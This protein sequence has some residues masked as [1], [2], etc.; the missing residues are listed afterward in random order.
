M[1][2]IVSIDNIHDLG[3]EFLQV[4]SWVA[5]QVHLKDGLRSD[6]RSTNTIQVKVTRD[7]LKHCTTARSGPFTSATLD[8]TLHLELQIWNALQPFDKFKSQPTI[9]T[10]NKLGWTS[11]KLSCVDFEGMR[12]LGHQIIWPTNIQTTQKQNQTVFQLLKPAA[13]DGMGSILALRK[14]LESTISLS[15]VVGNHLESILLHH[16]F[17][18]HHHHQHHPQRAHWDNPWLELANHWGTRSISAM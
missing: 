13:V 16:H 6:Q 7:H 1:N 11:T 12:N 9:Q 10:W 5:M 18:P 14:A 8:I 3:W 15:V 4:W 2:D 17:R